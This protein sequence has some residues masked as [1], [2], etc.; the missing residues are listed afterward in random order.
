MAMSGIARKLKIVL[1][2]IE[3]IWYIES[4]YSPRVEAE[5]TSQE[6]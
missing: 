2:P 3:R 6:H 1:N 5:E 4:G